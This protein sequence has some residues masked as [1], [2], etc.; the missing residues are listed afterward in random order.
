[1]NCEFGMCPE[2]NFA[3]LDIHHSQ[4]ILVIRMDMWRV[5][6]S[7]PLIQNNTQ[8]QTSKN[9]W[10]V[11]ML[12]HI[13]TFVNTPQSPRFQTMTVSF[14]WFWGHSSPLH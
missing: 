1:M 13:K 10:H 9:R 14:I 12:K 5:M 7:T 6:L 8:I 2:N 3:G 11:Y 4:I